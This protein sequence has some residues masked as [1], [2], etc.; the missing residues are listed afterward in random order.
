MRVRDRMAPSAGFVLGGIGWA[1]TSQLSAMRI[2]DSCE[3]VGTGQTLVVGLAGLCLAAIGGAISWGA[4]RT[5]QSRTHLFIARVS[6]CSD[7]AFA[8]AIA[9]HIAATLLIPR[10]LT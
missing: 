4:L 7:I 3:Q 8:L 2:S 6:L 9:F 1:G 5:V 10:C